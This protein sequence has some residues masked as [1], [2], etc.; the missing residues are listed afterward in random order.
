M[1]P[2]SLDIARVHAKL[3]LMRD[4]LDDLDAAGPIDAQRLAGNR[5]L[6]RAVERI[7][8]QLVDTAVSVN[9]HVTVA[10]TGKAPPSYRES[11]AA[12]ATAGAIPAALAEALVPSVGMRN[13]LVHEYTSADLA[14]VAG[15]VPLASEQ[16]GAY[17]RA[18]AQW[19]LAQSG[20]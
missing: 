15:A 4:L 13:V 14:R 19:L 17:V 18:V 5:L 7:L 2:R 6:L 9:S 12:A 3:R 1:T 11:F 20:T 8:T 10:V 16:Y